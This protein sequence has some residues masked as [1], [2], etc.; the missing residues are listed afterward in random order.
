MEN[1]LFAI[2]ATVYVLGGFH[3]FSESAPFMRMS[4]DV[5]MFCVAATLDF[6][7]ARD[8]LAHMSHFFAKVLPDPNV[9]DAEEVKNP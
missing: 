9:K 6:Y 3:L 5:G 7:T 1:L 4:F 8:F 2:P